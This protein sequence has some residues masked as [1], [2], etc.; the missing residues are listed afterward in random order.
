MASGLAQAGYDRKAGCKKSN[1]E[2]ADT[3]GQKWLCN[4]TGYSFNRVE[5]VSPYRLRQR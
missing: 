2:T 4:Y 3:T 1:G 5:W